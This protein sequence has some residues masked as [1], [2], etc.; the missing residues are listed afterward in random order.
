MFRLALALAA[1]AGLLAP[2]TAAPNDKADPNP[3][4]LEVPPEELSKARELVQRLGNE[5]YAEREAAERELA[6]MGRLARPALLDGVNTDPDP[7]VRARC[8]T[9]LPKATAEEVKARLDAFMADAEGKYEHDLPGWHK[10]RAAVRGEWKMFGWTYTARPDSDLAAREL[11][12]EFMQA[13]GGRKLLAAVD[14]PPDELGRAVAARKQDL[15]S[16]RFPR[17]PNAKAYAPTA[18]EVAV[19]VFAESQVSSRRV[20]RSTALTSVIT[21][22]GLPTLVRGSDGRAKALQAVMGAWFDSRTE[23]AE[24]YSALSLANSMQNEQ[25]ACR[26]ASRMMATNGLQGFYKGQALATLV[27]HKATD[28]LPAIERAF[29]DTAILTTMVRV[30]NGQQVRQSV[31]VRDAALAAALVM[32]GQDPSAYGFDAFPRS[33]GNVNFSYTW[34]RIP[35]DKRKAAFEKWNEWRQK[36]P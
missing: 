28:Q 6:Q 11:F 19:A 31:E 32:T 2:A 13:P 33:A 35:E 8:G 27:R 22:S 3:K 10:L 36:N 1:V 7:E 16:A 34:A 21:T 15:Y 23:P 17:T 29:T 12:I 24:L 18:A 20:P 30:V 4:S 14:G 26:L 5:V 25:A 9:L